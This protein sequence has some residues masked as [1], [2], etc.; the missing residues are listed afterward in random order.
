MLPGLDG[1]GLIERA[2]DEGL[3]TPILAV[4][5][6]GN[7]H[8]KVATLSLGADDY[9]AKPFGMAEFM[10]RVQALARRSRIAPPSDARAG[11]RVPRAAH[12]PRPAPRLPASAPRAGRS[13]RG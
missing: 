2:R 8:D 13:T 3:M 7:E 10:A 9:L 6:R 1:W 12:R 5:A 4:S 11:A